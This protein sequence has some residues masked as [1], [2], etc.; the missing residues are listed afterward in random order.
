MLDLQEGK[1]FSWYVLWS[2]GTNGQLEGHVCCCLVWAGEGWVGPL[3][4]TVAIP[5]DRLTCCCWHMWALLSS[6]VGRSGPLLLGRYGWGMGC[7]PKSASES[8]AVTTYESSHLV[9]AGLSLSWLSWQREQAFHIYLLIDFLP[10]PVASSE[11]QTSLVPK[12][13]KWEIKRKPKKLT[14]CNS[15]ASPLSS[16]Y[17][18]KSFYDCWMISKVDLEGKNREK[19]VYTT[20]SQNPQLYLNGPVNNNKWL[21][22]CQ[23]IFSSYVFTRY[24]LSPYKVGT[25][26][27]SEDSTINKKALLPGNVLI[28]VEKKNINK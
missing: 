16:L 4:S 1:H 3:V 6:T 7:P 27:C 17:T 25:V 24:L 18:S 5:A 15:L 13:A 28:L 23:T 11:L 22:R 2:P 19:R 20:L 14:L 10:M 26:L 21:E 8:T 9:S 12:S